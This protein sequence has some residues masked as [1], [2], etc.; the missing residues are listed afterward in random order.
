MEGSRLLAEN[1][2]LREQVLQLQNANEA[3]S[4]RPSFREI[5]AVKSRL[6]AKLLEFGGLVAELG[7]LQKVETEPRCRSQ[8]A[9]RK[10]PDERQWRSGLCLQEVENAMLP[11]ITE[12]K[13]FPRR[14]MWC[15]LKHHWQSDKTNTW[16]RG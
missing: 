15:V 6:E 14:T 4:N 7:Q 8:T 10:S 16:Q 13:Y 3:R 5:D 1:L 12:D 9:T 2:S 11:T